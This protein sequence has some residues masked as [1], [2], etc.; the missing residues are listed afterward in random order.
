MQNDEELVY[1]IT[2]Y[3]Y[4]FGMLVQESCFQMPLMSYK[5]IIGLMKL[6]YLLLQLEVLYDQ[7][8]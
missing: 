2:Y 4:I 3:Q 5:V 8:L 6:Y 7:E 1:Q